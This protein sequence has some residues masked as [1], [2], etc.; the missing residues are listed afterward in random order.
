M[1]VWIQ[2]IVVILAVGGCVAFV[3]FQAVQ[4]LRGRKSRLNS[5]GSCKTC[6]PTPATDQPKSQRTAIIPADMLRRR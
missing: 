4:S 3:V 5:C 2:T 1:P 6:A